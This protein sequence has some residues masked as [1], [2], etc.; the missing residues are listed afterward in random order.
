MLAKRSVSL[1]FNFLLV[2]VRDRER[3]KPQISS[4]WKIM[5]LLY[6]LIIILTFNF[7]KRFMT[8]FITIHYLQILPLVFAI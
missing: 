7:I 2:E 6:S 3:V 4:S 8:N 5:Q 1:D